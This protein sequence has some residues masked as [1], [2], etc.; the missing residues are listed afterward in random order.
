M[1]RSDASMDYWTMDLVIDP[2]DPAQNT[3]Y[4][5]VYGGWGGPP[6]GLGGLY[7]T[8]NRGASWTQLRSDDGVTSCAFNPLNTNELYITTEDEGLLFCGNIRSASPTINPVLNYPFGQPQR[9]F[10]NPYNP[11]EVWVTSFGNGLR[12]GSA[13]SAPGILS[14][15]SLP[16]SGIAQISLQ[17]G[18]P[19]A[20]Y[21]ILGSTNLMNWTPLGTNTTDNNGAIQFQDSHA[22]NSLRFYKSQAL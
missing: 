19:G 20:D 11:A 3:W 17:A 5:G 15:M 12:V 18:S 4:V 10:F 22:T 13:V 9:V 16:Q 8:A 21:A 2:T 1:D 6:N 7:R 14:V